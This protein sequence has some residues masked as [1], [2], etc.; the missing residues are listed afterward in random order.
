MAFAP[1]EARPLV[2][3]VKLFRGTAIQLSYRWATGQLATDPKGRAVLLW[4][5]PSRSGTSRSLCRQLFGV[6]TATMVGVVLVLVGNGVLLFPLGIALIVMGV[7]VS[8]VVIAGLCIVGAS[9]IMT[10]WRGLLAHR[11]EREL[12]AR[13]PR[14][15]GVRWRIDCLAAVPARSGHGGR[16]L[17]AF[18]DRADACDA[19]VVLHCIPLNVA[20]YRRH[21]FHVA[22][23]DCPDGQRLMLR[24]ARSPRHRA[25][26]AR[27]RVG[28]GTSGA[29]GRTTPTATDAQ[30]TPGQVVNR[31]GRPRD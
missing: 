25:R 20:F 24:R 27:D 9:L 21:G 3:A 31:I 2:G 6:V 19:E 30:R 7:A 18:L 29:G 12:T 10:C 14:P 16:L 15:A 23:G 4:S 1:Y 17:D 11:I 28:R 8:P 13:L 22:A 5:A 26:Q